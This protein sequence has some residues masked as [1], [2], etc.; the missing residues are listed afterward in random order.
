MQ[1]TFDCP[2]L[3]TRVTISI[4]RQWIGFSKHGFEFYNF[5]HNQWY[6]HFQKHMA[7]KLW[8]TPEMADFI[9]SNIQP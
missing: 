4:I 1:K 6:S 7:D 3:K 5:M 9:N 2:H 8:F